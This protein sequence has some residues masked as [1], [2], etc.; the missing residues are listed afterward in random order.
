MEAQKSIELIET[1]FKESKKSFSNNAFYFILWGVIL[2]LAGLAEYLLVG[3]ENN[4]MVWPVVTTLGGL[5][6][7]IYGIK[8]GKK[9]RVTTMGDRMIMLIWL[10]FMFFLVFAITYAIYNH[11]TPHAIIMAGTAYATFLTGGVSRFKPLLF[12]SL[13]LAIGAVLAGFVIPMED[14]GLL[15]AI[16]I[17]LGYLVPGILLRRSENA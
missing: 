6:S 12:G 13:A 16:T 17:T 9:Q 11:L 15:F 4:W 8:E 7:M 2:A 3:M 14:H 10:G 1:M 5:V